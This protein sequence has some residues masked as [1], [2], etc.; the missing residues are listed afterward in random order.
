MNI[1]KIVISTLV[2]SQISVSFAFSQFPEI[3]ADDVRSW[4]TGKRKAVVVDTRQPAEYAAAHIPGAIN[5][6]AERVKGERSKLPR[7]V[8]TPVIFYCRGA[9]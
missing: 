6:P 2:I 5:I 3:G 8:S 9:G 4:M 1:L 7:D